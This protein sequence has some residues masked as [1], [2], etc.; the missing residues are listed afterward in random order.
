LPGYNNETTVLEKVR[1]FF[2]VIQQKSK[3]QK[4]FLSTPFHYPPINV[5]KNIF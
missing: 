2:K 1:L 3:E 5:I 4:D